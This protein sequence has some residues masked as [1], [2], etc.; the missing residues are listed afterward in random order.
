MNSITKKMLLI[1]F[2]LLPS[3]CAHYPQQ[4]SYYPGNAAYSSGYTIMHRN[5]YGER[6][7]HYDN[8]YRQGDA[9]FS[10]HDH[11]DQHSVQRQWGNN[12]P[13]SRHQHDRGH[14][15]SFSDGN[16]RQHDG[17]SD[18]HHNNFERRNYR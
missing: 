2:A 11:H 12:H 16:S 18:S 13:E 7:D 1:G 6:P 15:R 9:Y 8:G 5:Y 3:A 17:D 14:D 10:H 4:H